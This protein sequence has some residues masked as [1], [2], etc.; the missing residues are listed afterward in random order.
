M[1]GFVN[2]CSPKKIVVYKNILKILMFFHTL[3]TFL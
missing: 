1:F 3:F 2:I